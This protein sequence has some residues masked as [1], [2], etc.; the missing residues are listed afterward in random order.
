MKSLSTLTAIIDNQNIISDARLKRTETKTNTSQSVRS[1]NHFLGLYP[2]TR[3]GSLQCFPMPPSW[4]GG[5]S[6][7]LP[8]IPPPLLAHRASFL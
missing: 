5:G 8:T 7:P 2:G 3:S 4:W 1:R 6:L